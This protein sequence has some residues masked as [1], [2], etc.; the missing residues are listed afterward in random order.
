MGN[1]S[2]KPKASKASQVPPVPKSPELIDPESAW[3]PSTV[4]TM[5]LELMVLEGMIQLEKEIEWKSCLGQPFPTE[6]QEEV[7]LFKSFCE[8]GFALPASDFFQELLQFY[9][10]ELH[11]LTPNG[12]SY[13]A[14]FQHF[15]EAFLGIEPLLPFFRYLFH[16]KGQ[17]NNQNPRVVGGAGI[18]LR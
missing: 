12:V 6:A 3:R 8:R 14:N 4:G 1:K 9:G 17:S 10:L 13:I 5:D 2:Q 15:F 18:Q 16:I 11:H 7:V